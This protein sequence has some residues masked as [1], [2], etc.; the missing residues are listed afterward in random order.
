MKNQILIEHQDGDCLYTVK[1]VEMKL[2]EDGL[3]M[4][5]DSHENKDCFLGFLPSPTLYLEDV[6][7]SAHSIREINNEVISIRHGWED[8]DGTE[9]FSEISRIYIGQHQP[10]DNTKIILK[11]ISDNEIEISWESDAP[12]F[13][14]YDERAKRNNVKAH[15]IYR[16]D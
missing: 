15:A 1:S 10:L 11:R 3:D 9:K 7:I 16:H 2:H 8:S 14:Y 12:D 6:T 5:I 4:E 13:N